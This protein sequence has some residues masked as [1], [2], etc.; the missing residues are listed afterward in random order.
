MPELHRPT[1]ATVTKRPKP[2]KPARPH[3]GGKKPAAI[4]LV[5]LEKLCALQCTDED[6]AAWFGC[7]TKT[8]QRRKDE[9]TFAEVMERGRGKG[10]VSLRRKQMELALAGDK[11]MLVWLGKQLLGQRDRFD[12]QITGAGGGPIEYL[13]IVL[14]RITDL[15]SQCK[16]S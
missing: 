15:P 16:E 1:V 13:S 9:A 11:T 14:P 8:I 2:D 6:I 3:T 7:A 10:R 5:E 4:D 12:A